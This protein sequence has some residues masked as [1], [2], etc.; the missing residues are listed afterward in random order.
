[1]TITRVMP[2]PWFRAQVSARCIA[3]IARFYNIHEPYRVANTDI[4]ERQLGP[5]VLPN[6]QRPPVWTR[7]QQIKLLESIWDGLPIG[8]YVYNLSGLDHP[9]DGW[10]LDGQQR[11]TAILAYVAG[12]FPVYGYRFPDLDIVERCGF[13]NQP[14]GTMQT[15]ILSMGECREVYDRLAY[16]GTPHDQKDAS[17]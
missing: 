2:Q 15:G 11:I 17:K 9:C 7:T 14:I 3:E 10:L 6:F 16:G 1:M 8:S 12:E 5:F 13:M 4:G